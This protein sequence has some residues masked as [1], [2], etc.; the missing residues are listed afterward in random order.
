MSTR[1]CFGCVSV[2]I[3]ILSFTVPSQAADVTFYVGGINPGSIEYR[4][5]QVSLDGSPVFGFRI[6]T[7]FVP[8]F[9]I[10]HTV[11]FSSDFLFPRNV[12]GV[13]DSK[14]FLFNSNLLFSL[15]TGKVV[16]YL[17]AGIGL[18]HQYG[19]SDLPVGTDPA[20][21]YGGGVKVPRIKGPLG[22]RFDVR[23][24]RVGFVTDTVNMLEV[25]GGI[26]ISTGR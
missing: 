22:L 18:V 12:E 11:A 23:G 14:G 21:N 10:E 6:G 26:I 8:F 24:Y 5:E 2:F 13:S 7:D 1:Y 19:S 4:G 9:G 25:S 3:L 17:T 16:P 15:P 20:F